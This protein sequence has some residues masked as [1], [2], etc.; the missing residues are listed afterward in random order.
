[1]G[2]LK[3]ENISAFLDQKLFGM[4]SQKVMSIRVMIH[5]EIQITVASGNQEFLAKFM[6]ICVAKDAINTFTKLFHIWMVTRS[7]SV[8]FFISES[9]FDPHFQI[10]MSDSTLWDGI[11]IRAISVEEKNHE[12]KRRT[13][14]RK[15]VVGSIR[16]KTEVTY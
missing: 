4:I 11:V 12:R 7:L 3:R 10:L 6:A 14:K 13:I 1:M 9:C 2:A 5:V 15:I 16:A 8:F